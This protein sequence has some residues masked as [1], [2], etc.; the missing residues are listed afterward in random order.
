LA[1][2]VAHVPSILPQLLR[3]IL[4]VVIVSAAGSISGS[5]VVEVAFGRWGWNTVVNK[6]GENCDFV[7]C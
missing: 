2:D 1:R 5:L 6:V 4:S 3:V 7:L